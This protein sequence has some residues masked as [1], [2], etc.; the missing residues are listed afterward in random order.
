MRLS[1]GGEARSRSVALKKKRCRQAKAAA[2]I[3]ALQG[4]REGLSPE[5]MR[6]HKLVFR[7]KRSRV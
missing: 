1:C 3:P 5:P 7:G 2:T 4:K 6:T